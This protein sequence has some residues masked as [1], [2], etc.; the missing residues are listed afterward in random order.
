MLHFTPKETAFYGDFAVLAQHGSSA[1]DLLRDTLSD[2]QQVEQRVAR[3]KALE[4]RGDEATHGILVRLNKTFITPFDREDIHR[5]ASSLDDVLDLIY[6]AGERVLFYRI[7]GPSR[8]ASELAAVIV[9]Q[10]KQ[11][12][13][14]IEKLHDPKSLLSHCIEINRLENEADRLLRAA[15][16]GLFDNEKDAFSLIKWKELY[17]VLEAATDRAEDVANVLESIVVKNS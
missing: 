7:P 8:S 10:C 6:S 12:S 13:A 5:L 11:I 14:A 4:H 9:E 3:L 17:E 16:A 2:F 1:A 15:I